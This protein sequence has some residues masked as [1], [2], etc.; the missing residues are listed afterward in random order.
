MV[1]ALIPAR[2]DS[3]A[4][5]RKNLVDVCGKPLIAWTIEAALKARCRV[6]VSTDDKE[7]AD[8]SVDNGAFVIKRPKELAEDHVHTIYTILHALDWLDIEDNE[9]VTMLLPTSPLRTASDIIRGLGILAAGAPSVIG[10]YKVTPYHS[11]RTIHKNR[12]IPLAFTGDLVNPNRED[13]PAVYAVNGAFFAA[14]ASTLR[15]SKTFHVSGSV[16]YVMPLIRSVDVDCYDDL[17][18]V[19]LLQENK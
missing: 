12:L 14:M 5:L 6:V 4:V 8:Y 15:K 3:R 11:L 18:F 17:D 9:M 1:M 16:P 7:I 2:G 13:S 19:R 10:V